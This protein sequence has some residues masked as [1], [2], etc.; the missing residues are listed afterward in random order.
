[1]AAVQ[2]VVS[3]ARSFI[4]RKSLEVKGFVEVV[5][6]AGM[7]ELEALIQRNDE[8]KEKLAQFAKET[9][10]R[11]RV[12]LEQ[13]AQ[14]KVLEA[15]E[16]VQKTMLAAAPLAAQHA[17][18]TSQ[19]AAQEI[20][21]KLGEAEQ[22][23]QDKLEEA[24][25]FLLER[26][27]EGKAKM[28]KAVLS[29]LVNRL[30][31]VQVDL[32]KVKAAASE[33]EQRF[34]A[35]M[36]LQQVN[37]MV[38]TLDSELDNANQAAAPLTLDGGKSFVVASMAKMILEAL[39][40]HC[41]KSS[42]AREDLFVQISP[43]AADGKVTEAEFIAYL[44]RV[45]EL[46][47]RPDLAFS[48]EQRLAIF[49]Q[50]DADKDSMISKSDFV[51]MFRDRYICTH[52]VSIT[53]GLDIAQSKTIDTLLVDDVVEAL[54]EPKSLDAMGLI[55]VEVRVLKDG[56]TGWVTTQG[57]QGTTH[58][59]PFTAY[60]AFIKRLDRTI[61]ST[62]STLL[63]TSEF[64]ASKSAELREC[65]Q[66][67]LADAKS[68]LSTIRPKVNTLRSKLE[69]L[70]KKIEEG[71]REHT[72]REEFERRKQEEKKDRK[73]VSLVLSTI[74]EKVTKIQAV[75]HSLEQAAAPFTSVSESDLATV[76]NPITVR[77]ATTDAADAVTEAIADAKGCLKAHEG[78]AAKATKG[79]WNDAKIEM[80]K[81]K[82]Q[83]E[84]ADK[85]GKALLETVRTSCDKVTEQKIGQVS[86]ALRSTVQSRAIS[87]EALY[88]ELAGDDGERIS[89]ASFSRYLDSL[90]HIAFSD[91]QRQLLF[92]RSGSGGITRRSFFA[93]IE[94]YFRCVKEIAITSEFDIKVST[95][96]R[97]LEP[98]EFVEVLNG[99]QSD[100][101]LGVTRIQARVLADGKLGWI[102]AKGNQGTPFLEECSK[103]CYFSTDAVTMQD[104]FTTD[105]CIEV[106]AVKPGEVLEVVEGP[107]KEVLGNAI[108]AQ[109][110]AV[111]DGAVGWFTVRS[112][113]GED[114]VQHTKS[115]FSCRQGIALTN[116]MNI[117]ECSVLRKLD[118]GEALVVLEG[119]VED[120]AAG[121]TRIRAKATKDNMEGWVTTK[122]NAGSV[123]VEESGR[124]YVVT[125]AMPLQSTFQSDSAADVRMLA[126]QE[127]I[128]LM[129]GPTEEK[130]NAAVRV[131]V[132]AVTDGRTGWISLR[133]ET[134]R[135]WSPVYRCVSTSALTDALETSKGERV[136]SLEP[137]ETV[138]L[139]EGPKEDPVDGVLR[140]RG[141]T[142]KDGV[143]GWATILGADG[144]P[145]LECV[146]LA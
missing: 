108:R 39:N 117:K 129:D 123:Y 73:A 140:L 51:D 121:V 98:G 12:A 36:L 35:K 139:L 67:P 48:S 4:D 64:I 89:E 75:L 74:A 59:S 53:D 125:V 20:V 104:R 106:R 25:K 27:R 26:Q 93:M 70:C 5:A 80:A 65:R 135:L 24:R 99:P 72:K 96:L 136:C 141:R 8:A 127:E 107:R 77:K 1:V 60:T 143:V 23:A 131:N 2:Q 144:V 76:S 102:T 41:N 110:K 120:E 56:T 86:A 103:P 21:E 113:Q 122:G 142:E 62:Q 145:L 97:K 31:S 119:P 126:E 44:E 91:E 42:L 82:K 17:E 124:T 33:H 114:C 92:Q 57:N 28:D 78:R 128:E 90:Q 133:R 137:G 94:R 3:E 146:P 55:R 95:T 111:S 87:I 37:E 11:K 47:S 16:A 132:R 10:D 84:A 38:S 18:E 52:E 32:A 49:E 83:V 138:E 69:Q 109:G 54:S 14:A 40:E 66:G 115:T 30:N 68:E 81:F 61:S 130:S 7:R 134:M 29:K 6:V 46:C 88:A 43:G 19:D 79:P 71:K 15:E 22:E 58:F 116:D 9:E 63:K 101:S 50:L 34:V 85:R 45:P 100:D 105:G 13:Q 112:K 118:K